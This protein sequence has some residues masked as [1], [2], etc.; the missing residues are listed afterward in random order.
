[1][2]IN[3]TIQDVEAPFAT[4]TCIKC[5]KPRS[6]AMYIPLRSQFS[7]Q[8]WSS[9]CNE[10]I[11]SYLKQNNFSWD[12][13][14]KLCQ[15]FDIPFI[16]K[17]F[18]RL[19]DANGANVFPI[20]A[21]VFLGE[22]FKGLGWGDYYKEFL[23]LK[24]AGK[25]EEELPLISDAERKK[26]QEKWGFNYDDEA[27]HYLENLYDGLLLTQNING[28]LQSDQ[29]IKI[30]KIS[31]EIDCRIRAGSDFDK[32]L[33]SYDTLV[34]TA[35]FT[36]KN[37]KNAN[38]FDSVGELVKWL[39]KSGWVNQFYDG[40]TRDVV[41]ETIKNIQTYNQRLYTNESGIGEQ[42]HDRVEGLRNVANSE[43]YYDLQQSYDMDEFENAGYEE[44]MN[45]EFNPEV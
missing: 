27:L 36:P 28:A 19:H 29:A 31:Y 6:A 15:Y 1:M 13:A 18:E 5:G 17:E 2:A 3:P 21:R 20:Y 35:E 32:V 33:K 7:N 41:D 12:A 38:D 11:E 30:C 24:E 45:D 22:E 8:G 10:C 14:D 42:I 37:T 25:L 40:V 44:L 4:R 34:K 39:E 23:K 26:L 16:P 9:I 43:S